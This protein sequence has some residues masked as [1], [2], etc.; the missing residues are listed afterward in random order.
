[1]TSYYLS[2]L[3]LVP[4]VFITPTFSSQTNCDGMVLFSWSPSYCQS[5][6]IIFPLTRYPTLSPIKCAHECSS[7]KLKLRPRVSK[8]MRHSRLITDFQNFNVHCI[9]GL[10]MFGRLVFTSNCRIPKNG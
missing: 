2:E 7:T 1:M 5:Y 3:L 9:S 4:M 6:S 8:L 10:G